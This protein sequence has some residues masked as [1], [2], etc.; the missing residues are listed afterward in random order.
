VDLVISDVIM[1]T[2]GGTDLLEALSRR[3]PR[4]PVLLMSGYTDRFLETEIANF[5]KK[6]FTSAALLTEVRTLLDA[7]EKPAND[8]LEEEH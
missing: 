7:H 3:Y 5:I 4:L 6:P 1:P 8:N 2:M